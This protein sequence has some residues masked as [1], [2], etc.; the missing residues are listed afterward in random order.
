MWETVPEP[1]DGQ[2]NAGNTLGCVSH[3]LKVP[4]GWVVRTITYGYNIGATTHQ[5]FV[6]DPEHKWQLES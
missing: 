3:R 1:N 4:G 2:Y 5:V 6:A